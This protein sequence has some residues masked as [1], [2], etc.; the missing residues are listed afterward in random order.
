M[1][2]LVD[3]SVG[4][5]GFSS[6]R[7]RRAFGSAD[8]NEAFDRDEPSDGCNDA[9]DDDAASSANDDETDSADLSGEADDD[10]ESGA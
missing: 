3:D 8:A 2:C 10:A 4:G 1:V 6:L 9:A 5:C 7:S